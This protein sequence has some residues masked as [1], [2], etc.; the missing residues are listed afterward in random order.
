[1]QTHRDVAPG[2][3]QLSRGH[4]IHRFAQTMPR[5]S[6]GA[7]VTVSEIRPHVVISGPSGL[8]A[9]FGGVPIRITFLNFA[10]QGC[11]YSPTL[12][13]TVVPIDGD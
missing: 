7:M 13:G 6:D 4:D 2:L 3:F 5:H 10:I 1:M 9:Q 12:G 8:H 11:R